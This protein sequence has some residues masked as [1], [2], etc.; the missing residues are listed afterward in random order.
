[1]P[2]DL[3]VVCRVPRASVMRA[4]KALEQAG[5]CTRQVELDRPGETVLVVTE[6]AQTFF[7]TIGPDVGEPT[8]ASDLDLSGSPDLRS[9]SSQENSG[10]PDLRSQDLARSRRIKKS[11]HGR[12]RKDPLKVPARAWAAAD[13]LRGKVLEVN[14]SAMVGTRPWGGDTGLRLDWAYSFRGLGDLTLKA[15]RNAGPATDAD[16]WN[17]IAKT[18]HWLFHGQDSSCRFVVESPA[19]LRAKWDAIQAVR[20]NQQLQQPAKGADGRPDPI[21]ERSYKRLNPGDM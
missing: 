10:S 6:Q 4:I 21:A 19:S 1:V 18:V 17:A 5:F 15:L 12:R 9:T 11:E 2:S 13:Y 8:R 16:A 14:A 20:R 7:L 3:T